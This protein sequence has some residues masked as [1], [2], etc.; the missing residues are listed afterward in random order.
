[1][2]PGD[3]R[4]RGTRTRQEPLRLGP[5]VTNVRQIPGIPALLA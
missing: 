1:V 2:P 4:L 5:P 3:A